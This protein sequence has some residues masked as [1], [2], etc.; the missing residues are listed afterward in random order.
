MVRSKSWM[1]MVVFA[2][3][4]GEPLGALDAPAGAADAPGTGPDAPVAVLD[5]PIADPDAPAAQPTV[6]YVVRHAETTGVGSDPALSA[7]GEARA[8]SLALRLAEAHVVAIYTSQYRRTHDTAVPASTAAGVAIETMRVDGSNA[9]TYGEELATAARAHGGT[10]D[11]LI[12]G[13]SN[14]VPA[15]V[16]ALGGAAIAPI[17]ETEFDRLYTITLAPGGAQVAEETY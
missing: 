3:C 7:Q 10:G 12:V 15:T 8:A 1:W 2:A 6:V 5:A 4:G 17:T 14:T 13:H 16:L 9:A 11:V